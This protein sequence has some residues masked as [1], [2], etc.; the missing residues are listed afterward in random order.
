MFVLSF[1]LQLIAWGSAEV[2]AEE[3]S[4]VRDSLK[5]CRVDTTSY[6]IEDGIHD[7]LT[8]SW[9]NQESKDKFWQKIATPWFKSLDSPNGTMPL[10][11]VSSAVQETSPSATEQKTTPITAQIEHGAQQH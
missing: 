7:S 2:L 5:Q 9:W 6:E 8:V 11:K 1:A 4:R 10:Q 3:I